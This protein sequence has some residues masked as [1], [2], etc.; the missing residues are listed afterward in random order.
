MS[1]Q[2]EW[3]HLKWWTFLIHSNTICLIVVIEGLFCTLLG[4]VQQIRKTIMWFCVVVIG[5]FF[6]GRDVCVHSQHA[7][8]LLHSNNKQ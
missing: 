2:T 3:S 6:G 7:L 5:L 4:N 1:Q 8:V